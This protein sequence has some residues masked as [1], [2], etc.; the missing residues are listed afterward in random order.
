MGP[1]VTTLTPIFKKTSM[2]PRMGGYPQPNN[3]PQQN[4]LTGESMEPCRKHTYICGSDEWITDDAEVS[5][6][7][8]S[9]AKGGESAD[10][11]IAALAPNG[12]WC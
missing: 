2:P 10:N 9:F 12:C 4:N 6:A 11:S 5:I 1:A 7:A 8:N 3:Q